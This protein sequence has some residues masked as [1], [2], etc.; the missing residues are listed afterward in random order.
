[1]G[2]P[3]CPLAVNKRQTMRAFLAFLALALCMVY[4]VSGEKLTVDGR[5]IK[6]SNGRTRIY[7]GFNSVRKGFP[8]Y[9]DA[10]GA[11]V[12]VTNN[13]VLDLLHEW[14]FNAIRLG[15]MWAGA[16]PVRGQYNDTYLDILGG[17]IKEMGARNIS[18]L[19]DMHQD[20]ISSVYHSYDGMP[21][22]LIES[23]PP[24]KHPYPWPVKNIRY[25]AEGYITEA[26]ATAFQNFYDNKADSHAAF[27]S[28]WKKIVKTFNSKDYDSI[29]GYELINEPFAGNFYE[30]P[31]L[32]L[33]GVAGSKN[34]APLYD[35]ANDAIRA[36]DP[37]ALVFYEPVTWSIMRNGKYIG[38]GFDKVPGGDE[39]RNR[40]VLSFHYYCWYVSYGMAPKNESA[41]FKFAC[42][43]AL[44]PHVF[45][46]MDQ[47]VAQTGGSLFM[48]EFGNCKPDG[49]PAS[50][51]EIETKTAM[52]LAD[53]HF[54]SW[55]YWVSGF[56][57]SDGNIDWD[58][59]EAF[60]R[61]YARAIAGL[62][63][64]M[65]FDTVSGTFTLQY[66][67]DR[68]ITAPTEVYIPLVH[69]PDG[70]KV[71]LTEHFLWRHDDKRHVIE[72]FPSKTVVNMTKDPLVKLMV[73][74]DSEQK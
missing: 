25:W 66:V 67:Q 47:D 29:L 51:C 63:K 35:K 68:N 28:F 4:C 11:Q 33:P 42:D 39:F 74:P 71:Q 59:V 70:F 15:T 41:F 6:D 40:S 13:T 52:D 57:K 14:G 19:L 5:W 23:M 1:M 34:L 69:Y 20:V 32:L 22:W 7:H 45:K 58:V 30:D 36:V 46:A 16:E 3:Q 37:E 54:V 53:D 21:R 38:T 72:I 55:T 43:Q 26:V 49:N 9:P 62:P 27:L 24:A 73:I 17:M 48:T 60:C 2:I 61:P 64:L 10:T 56:F 18:T 44:A 12:D 65:Y 8:W 50:F 31:S